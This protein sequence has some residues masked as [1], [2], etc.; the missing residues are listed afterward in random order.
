[1]NHDLLMSTAKDLI[2]LLSC[3]V[4][5]TAPDPQRC[6][7]MDLPSVYR[8]AEEHMLSAAAAFALERTITLPENWQAAK[9]NAIRK[10][11]IHHAERKKVF[12][13]LE[14]NKIWYLPLKGIVLKDCC[15][16]P[17]MREMS[18]NDVLF[19]ISKGNIVKKCMQDLG[20][21]CT[22]FFKTDHG[23]DVYQKP[24]CVVFEMH[25][26]LVNRQ[27]FPVIF[28][29]YQNKT[30]LRKKDTG[31]SYA[32]HMS[33]EDFYVYLICHIYK[34]YSGSGTGLRSLLDIYVYCHRH[35][36][37][38]DWPYIDA[39]LAALGLKEYADGAR[40]LAKKIFSGQDLSEQEYKELCYYVE[41][42]A[43][44]QFKHSIEK[45]IA[46]NDGR[47]LKSKYILRRIFPTKDSLQ[48]YHP[49]VY[50]HMFLY[51]VMLIYRPIQGLIRHPKKLK[52][53]FAVI[54]RFQKDADDE[55]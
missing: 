2:Y 48:L 42:R 51:P 44:G 34:H 53:E 1:M 6:A 50:R 37:Q 46:K 13:M 54:R 27:A 52:K 10:Q 26:S 14:E 21:T 22:E 15:P 40:S 49:F 7:S 4:H 32:C 29:Y 17:A 55:K 18:D 31:S 47:F 12:Q 5:E 33:D 20:Y 11:I 9:G 16:K 28:E 24:P 45:K 39:T 41:S 36:S 8:L 3:A 43:Y 25:R 19:D 38:P 23:H 35:H 30:D